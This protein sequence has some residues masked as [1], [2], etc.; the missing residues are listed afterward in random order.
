VGR[1]P[2]GQLDAAAGRG[3]GHR[4][5][6]LARRVQHGVGGAVRHAR[7]QRDL[8]AVT[9]GHVPRARLQQRVGQERPQPDQVGRLEVA[10]DEHDLGD[11]GRPVERE[12]ER[13][14]AG[15]DGR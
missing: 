11:L 4:D 14:G 12:A 8:D 7:V 9:V 1:R 2:R 10:L 15:R 5:A 3:G 6:Q 13:G